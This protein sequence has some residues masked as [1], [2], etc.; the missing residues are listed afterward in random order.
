MA[1]P[2][3]NII[4]LKNQVLL[5]ENA[6]KLNIIVNN[7]DNLFGEVM[8]LNNLITNVNV[9]DIVLFNP[10]DCLILRYDNSFFY[11]VDNNKLIFKEVS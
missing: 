9:G 4:L 8:S 11:I 7:S 6:S 5:Q 3:P 1:V 10:N 2:V